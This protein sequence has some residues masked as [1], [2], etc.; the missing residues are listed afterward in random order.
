MMSSSPG[1]RS[2]PGPSSRRA[3]RS[4]NHDE[5][6]WEDPDR[7]DLPAGGPPPLLRS[8]A[9]HVLGD[10]P[11]PVGDPGPHG[12]RARPAP[13]STAR[14]R[15]P[16]PAHQGWLSAPPRHSPSGSARSG[17]GQWSARSPRSEEPFEGGGQQEQKKSPQTDGFTPTASASAAAMSTVVTSAASVFKV[18]PVGVVLKLGPVHDGQ[19]LN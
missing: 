7:F 11:G 13:R 4:A 8:R 18:A 6:R 15:R 9:A 2:R 3:W 17:Q 16:R 10:A 12:R 5:T 14:P 19:L 1:S